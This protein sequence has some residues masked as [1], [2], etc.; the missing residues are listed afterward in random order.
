MADAAVDA[1]AGVT[2]ATANGKE[3]GNKC[4]RNSKP[5]SQTHISA[6]VGKKAM[7]VCKITH[8]I[9]F[10]NYN[11][12]SSYGNHIHDDYTSATCK[13]PGPNH[14]HIATHH[15]LI[16]GSVTGVHTTIMPEQCNREVNHGPH[17]N[18]SQGYLYCAASG[19]QETKRHHE[20]QF[21]GQQGQ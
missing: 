21:R 12:C 16:G 8:I 3:R 17:P 1:V 10:S 14:N 15:N 19:F 6:T 5:C 9:S 13:M 7:D 20:A 4:I 11:Y 2:G 18:P